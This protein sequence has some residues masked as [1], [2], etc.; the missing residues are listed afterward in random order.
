MPEMPV[1]WRH[2]MVEMIRGAE[3]LSPEWFTGGPVLSPLEQISVYRRQWNLRIYDA[4]EEEIPGLAGLLGE[5]CDETIRA[6]M[7]D[8]PPS[9]W[10]LDRVA[11]NLPRWLQERGAPTAQL[12]MI[13]LDLAVQ[14]G[15]SAAAGATLRPED[16][17]TMPPLR[18]QPHVTLLRFTHNVHWLRS[19]STPADGE[20]VLELEA[21]DYPVVVFRR[22][23]KMRHWEMDLGAW[24]VL[25]G[26]D[27]GL[28]VEGAIEQ[29][30]NKDWLDPENLGA[31]IQKWFVDYAERN[32]LEV[33]D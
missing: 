22:G 21:G 26:I 14:N 12:E 7:R 9:D 32:L 1:D 4:I 13:S 11:D 2:Q 15:F 30:F 31:N 17:L 3:D 6:Y 27:D 29:A 10:T 19:T 23:I 8:Y 16:L 33:A 20:E 5:E 18:L 28:G 25:K 24:A